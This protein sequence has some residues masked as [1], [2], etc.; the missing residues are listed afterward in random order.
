VNAV[1][2]TEDYQV[3]AGACPC[4]LGLYRLPRGAACPCA[5]DAAPSRLARDG[6]VGAIQE[7]SGRACKVLPE[8]EDE[9]GITCGLVGLL[10]S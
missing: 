3:A 2:E 1:K 7:G 8:L 6:I 5:G 10:V 4:S 9:S